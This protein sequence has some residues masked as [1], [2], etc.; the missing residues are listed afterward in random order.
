M[1]LKTLLLLAI[2]KMPSRPKRMSLSDDFGARRVPDRDAVAGL[3]DAHLPRSPSI[4]I[5]ARQRSR[6]RHAGRCRTG[7]PRCGCPRSR[8]RSPSARRRRPESIASRSSA[9]SRGS[10]GRGPRRPGADT[11]MTLP[12]PA[13]TSDAPG[14]PSSVQAIDRSGPGR[15]TCRARAIDDVAVRA[16][17]R[18]P[19]AAA[20]QAQPTRSPLRAPGRTCRAAT[21]AAAKHARQH[22]HEV[23]RPV[24]PLCGSTSMRPCISM[25]M[26]WQNQ[27][28]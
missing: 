16:R 4:A 11:V 25:C 26:A 8:R 15:D 1:P 13:P 2:E 3:A 28:Q 20:R 19:P 22:A 23:R 18:A 7:C 24:R 21:S 10:S 17:H 5:A 9:R 27:V 14:S 6:A 12:S